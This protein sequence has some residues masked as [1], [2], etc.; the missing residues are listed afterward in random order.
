[1]RGHPS[2]PKI[3]MGSRMMLVSAPQSWVTME[4]TELPVACSIRSKKMARKRPVL[5]AVTMVR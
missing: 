2:K 5:Q 4:S 3:M 1:M